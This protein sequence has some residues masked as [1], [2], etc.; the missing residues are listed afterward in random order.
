MKQNRIM[1]IGI[2]GGIATGKS[3][4][5][6]IIRKEGF[7]V[8]DSDSIAREHVQRGSKGLKLVIEE[9][10]EDLLMDD[11]SLD[12]EKLGELIFRNEE[13]RRV[14]NDLL[15]PLIRESIASGIEKASEH[16]QVV[17]VDVPL[18]FEAR[19]QIEDSGIILDEVWVVYTDD[20]TQLSRLMKRN[21]YSHNEA[22]S[23]IRAQLAMEEKMRLADE[24]IDNSGSVEDTRKQV[25]G[26]LDKYR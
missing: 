1:V 7:L 23:R 24:T 17:F 5:S 8:I 9:F 2:T 21:G 3:T 13:K 14:L 25:L 4:V 11:G 10:G 26:L 16:H 19:D 18:L 15:H 12:R 22:L 20:S 6:N